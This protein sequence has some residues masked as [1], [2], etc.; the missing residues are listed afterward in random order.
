[1][2]PSLGQPPF[3]PGVSASQQAPPYY[4][5]AVAGNHMEHRAGYPFTRMGLHRLSFQP[6]SFDSSMA[7]KVGSANIDNRCLCPGT[8]NS[9]PW[10]YMSPQLHAALQ[11]TW[12]DNFQDAHNIP[13][14][15][16]KY[17]EKIHAPVNWPIQ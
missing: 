7:C 10:E 5:G 1:M 17:V 4:Y 15:A 3:L 2:N 6:A 14:R 11:H 12:Y 16:A 13:S 8:R 9:A